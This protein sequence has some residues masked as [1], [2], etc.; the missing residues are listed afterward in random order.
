MFSSFIH[1]CHEGSIAAKQCSDRTSAWRLRWDFM[2]SRLLKWGRLPGYNHLR[3]VNLKSGMIHYRFNRGDLQSLREVMLEEVYACDLPF[4]P[5]TVLDLGANIG[6]A[7]VWFSKRTHSALAGS[8]PCF[9]LAVEPVPGNAEVAEMNFRGNHISGEVI[10]AAVGL[11][12]GEAWFEARMESNLGRLVKE[13]AA[14][15]YS[16]VP[17]VGIQDLL[18]RFPTGQVDLVKMD[19][20]GGEEELLSHDTDWLPKV[21]ALLVEWHDDRA[22]SRPLIRNVEAAGFLHQRINVERQDNLSLFCRSAAD[23]SQRKGFSGENATH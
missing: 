23:D 8:G 19:I 7:S 6:L 5:R 12:S 22:D 18:D 9:V 3:E 15:G 2:F 1:S 13:N 16:R 11:Q 20:E 14:A 17:V 4:Q 10:H 21:K